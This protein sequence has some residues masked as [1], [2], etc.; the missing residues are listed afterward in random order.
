MAKPRSKLPSRTIQIYCRKCDQLLYK[1]AKGGKGS[2]VK[3]FKQRIV[4]DH[5]EQAGHCPK[6]QQ[7]FARETMIRG[8]VA[9]K[10]I[11]GKV[12]SK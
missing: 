10:I 2:L 6:C 5:T 12:W 9:F 8:A 4:Q 11:S 7:Q 3:C 1:Y